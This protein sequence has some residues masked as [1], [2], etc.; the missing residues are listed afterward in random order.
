MLLGQAIAILDNKKRISIP[1]KFRSYFTDEN[2]IIMSRGFEGC[3]V[4]R[5]NSEFDKWQEKI[6]QQSE[7]QKESRILSRQIF[8]NSEELMIDAKGRINIPASLLEIAN[9]KSKV[10]FVGMANKLEVWSEASWNTF[11]DETKDKLESA[12]SLLPDL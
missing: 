11:N 12:A 2:N 6:L 7:G 10:I 5:T 9:I 8:A 4:I 1:A 3:L